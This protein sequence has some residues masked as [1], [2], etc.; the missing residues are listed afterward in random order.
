MKPPEARSIPGRWR[1]YRRRC[2]RGHFMD[3]VIIRQTRILSEQI[4]LI[5]SMKDLADLGHDKLSPAQRALKFRYDRLE[6]ALIRL[7]RIEKRTLHPFTY[8]R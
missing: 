3:Q 1:R 2:R 7:Q 4:G 5:Y 8:Q 6:R